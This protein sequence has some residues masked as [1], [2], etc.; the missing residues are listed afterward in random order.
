[1]S[2]RFLLAAALA[3]GLAGCAGLQKEAPAAA[4]PLTCGARDV[5]VYFD[6]QSIELD[7]AAREVIDIAAKSLAGCTITQV[8]IVGSS[9]GAGPE[10]ANA[11]LSAQRAKVMADYLVDTFRWS[12]E[13]MQLLATGERGAVTDAGLNVPMRRRARIVVESVAP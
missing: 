13:T 1:M 11:E 5:N 12:R 7:R 8:R 10:D 9:D 3:A 6:A 4:G 2:P